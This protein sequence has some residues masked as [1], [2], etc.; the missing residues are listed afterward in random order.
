MNPIIGRDIQGD[1]T[2]PLSPVQEDLP[3]GG[4]ILRIMKPSARLITQTIV[5]IGRREV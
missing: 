1:M 5:Q 4:N 3:R 2:S